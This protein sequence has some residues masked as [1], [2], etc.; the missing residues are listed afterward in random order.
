M[1][2]VGE[3]PATAGTGAALACVAGL[4]RPDSVDVP[5]SDASV[6][7]LNPR[8]RAVWK[9]CSRSFS[10]HRRSNRYSGGGAVGNTSVRSGGS[11][12]RIAV[13]VSTAEFLLKARVPVSISKKIVPREKMSLR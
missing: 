12:L 1:R 9:R 13:S 5:E 10:R 2:C 8:S 6:S 11:S 3:D 7:R 4:A